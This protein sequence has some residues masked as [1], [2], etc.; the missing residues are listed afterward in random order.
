MPMGEDV[1]A[2][3][4]VRAFPETMTIEEIAAKLRTPKLAIDYSIDS[5]WRIAV[6]GIEG[7]RVHLC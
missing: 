1:R 5:E 3:V 6:G 7:Y 4:M 2:N